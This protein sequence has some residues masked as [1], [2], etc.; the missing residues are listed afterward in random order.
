MLY[1]LFI[2]FFCNDFAHVT[3]RKDR[4]D[5]MRIIKVILCFML[6]GALLVSCGNKKLLS[7]KQDV[8]EIELGNPITKDPLCYLKLDDLNENEINQIQEKAKVSIVDEILLE[9]IRLQKQYENIGEYKM[10]IEYLNES[11]EFKIQITCT[12]K[13]IVLGP[14]TI[15]IQEGMEINYNDYYSIYSYAIY[16]TPVFDSSK[17]D[18]EHEGEYPL[19]IEVDGYAGHTKRTVAVKVEKH[20]VSSIPNRKILDVPYYNQL[21][22]NAPN[23]CEATALYMALR[24]KNAINIDLKSFIET[25]PRTTTPYTGFSGNPFEKATNKGAYYTIFPSALIKHGS[26]YQAIRDISHANLEQI[27]DELANDHPVIVWV[28][29][30]FRKPQI[31]S[32]YFKKAPTNL[33]IVLLNGYDKDKDIFYVKDP[34]DKDLTEI[35]FQDFQ[36]SY[37]ALE[38]A[39]SVE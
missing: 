16:Q 26:F 36:I 34:I 7:L 21:D 18:I 35:S 22:V 37:Q 11:V 12:Q 33:H 5:M 4:G 9:D 27:I 31:G 10:K 8:F 32:Y 1:I 28:T 29:G 3:M 30:G 24:Y 38:F 20:S 15:N 14:C 23:G 13:P 2:I 17:V 6:V 39:I 19:I 25:Q